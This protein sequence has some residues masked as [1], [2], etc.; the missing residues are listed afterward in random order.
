MR[1]PGGGSGDIAVSED[2]EKTCQQTVTLFFQFKELAASKNE[3]QSDL[4][5]ELR[6]LESLRRNRQPE[7]ITVARMAH[8]IRIRLETCR[9]DEGSDSA[10]QPVFR[11]LFLHSFEQPV[12][13]AGRI[14]REVLMLC[15]K[16]EGFRAD[17]S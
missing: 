3:I 14:T 13:P 5:V 8:E 15:P 6:L 9:R 17:E 1:I 7:T 11:R 12:D 16:S 4:F 2:L 10:A